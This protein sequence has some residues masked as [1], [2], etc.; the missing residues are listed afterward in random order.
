LRFQRGTPHVDGDGV[1]VA[2]PNV[3]LFTTPYGTSAASAGSPQALTVGSG[4]ALVLTDGHAIEGLWDRPD[5]LEP[6][7]LTDLDGDPIGLTPG[8]TWIGLPEAG[9]VTIMS[10]AAADELLALAP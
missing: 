3:V 6:W 5:A 10:Q 1:Q 9:D 7:E 4:D 2:P 8:H